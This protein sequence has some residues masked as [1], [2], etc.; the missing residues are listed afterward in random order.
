MHENKTP[1]P[2]ITG[3]GIQS[4]VRMLNRG[5]S[6]AFFLFKRS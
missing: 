1:I 6:L 2:Q 4:F 3:D 5:V